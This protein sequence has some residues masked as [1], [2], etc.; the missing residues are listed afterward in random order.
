MSDNNVPLKSILDFARDLVRTP[1]RA[2]EDD[3]KDVLGLVSQWAKSRELEFNDLT[4]AAG[5]LAGGYFHYMSGKPGPSICL[6]VCVDTCE[7][8]AEETW[9]DSATSGKIDGD[10]L[11]GR[12]AADSKAAVSMF[13]HIFEAISRIGLDS[14]QLYV[15]LDADE[16]TGNFG[17]VKAFLEKVKKID[18]VF[19]GYPG[20]KEVVIG[21]RGFLRAKATV[22]GQAAHSGSSAI[23]ADNALVK[24][25]KL[26]GVIS[27][28]Q[29]PP[30]AAPRFPAVG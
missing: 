18:T 13:C 30:E 2:Y 25:A 11:H 23:A 14:G 24:M 4:D 10:P 27:S 20:D 26:I 6:D 12:G 19:I 9:Q 17:G 3:P 7:F 1:S 15:L 21:A 22:Y 5:K 29:L 16:H 8:G 28:A